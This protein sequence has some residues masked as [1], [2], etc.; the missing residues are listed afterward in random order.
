MH[1]EIDH[2]I[3]KNLQYLWQVCYQNAKHRKQLIF[4]R[5]TYIKVS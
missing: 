3:A 1:L 5:K 2:H 4:D